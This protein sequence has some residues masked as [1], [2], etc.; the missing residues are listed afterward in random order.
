MTNA[1][2]DSAAYLQEWHTRHPGATA[3]LLESLTD[4]MGLS[5]YQLLAEAMHEVPEPV[6]DLAC[7]DGYLVELLRRN[8]LCLGVD[9]NR[10]EL[11]AASR[12]LGPG[13]QLVQADAASLPFATASLGAVGCHYAL[14]LLQPLEGVLS[15]LARVLRQGGR[16]VGVLPSTPPQDTPNPIS[17]FRTAWQEVSTNW[18]VTIPP[19]QDDRA[20]E[21]EMLISLLEESR[22]TSTTVQTIS[23][24]K[25]MSIS[26]AS[27]N[28]LLTYL[29]DLL[30]PDG[31]RHLVHALEDG[32]ADLDDGSGWVTFVLCSDLVTAQRS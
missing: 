5:S 3:D 32:M 1:P 25:R 28:L 30:P 15:E 8:H 24:T 18:P 10:A 21:P 17:V 23:A 22:F 19:I 27:R 20:L 6:L 13:A 31:V 29:P 4:E 26:E 2:R 14:M 16:L 12:R 9:W 11:S 7:G